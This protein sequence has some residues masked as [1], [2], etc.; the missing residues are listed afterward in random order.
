MHNKMITT[1]STQAQGSP[2]RSPALFFSSTTLPVL[3]P[4]WLIGRLPLHLIIHRA[5]YG[6][7][8]VLEGCADEGNQVASQCFIM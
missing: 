6:G 8:Y 3:P 5:D 7:I 1:L 4:G 2:T